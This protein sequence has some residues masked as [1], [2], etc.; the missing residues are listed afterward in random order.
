M[1]KYR[2]CIAWKMTRMGRRCA[3]YKPLYGIDD[4]MGDIMDVGGYYRRCIAWKMTPA[5]RRCAKYERLRGVEGLE[6]DILFS[7]R[8]MGDFTIVDINLP[9]GVI[10]PEDLKVI[11]VDSLP[12]PKPGSGI[13]LSGRAPIWLYGYLVHHYHIASWVGIY[14]PRLGGAVIVA[15]HTPSKHVGDVVKF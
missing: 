7:S 5:G 3:K 14:D 15:S 9:S 11:D 2:T 8:D 1:G 13:V 4:A 10:T 6:G 12:I